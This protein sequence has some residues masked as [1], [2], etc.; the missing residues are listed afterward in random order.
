M[1]DLNPENYISENQ[2]DFEIQVLELRISDLK[3]QVNE[4]L[5]MIRNIE[6]NNDIPLHFAVQYQETIILLNDGIINLQNK[7][8]NLFHLKFYRPAVGH[9]RPAERSRSRARSNSRARSRSRSRS[10]SNSRARSN[11]RRRDQFESDFSD[12]DSEEESKKGVENSE[13]KD[14]YIKTSE[15]KEERNCSVCLT[16]FNA[17]EKYV[18]TPCKHSFHRT[19]ILEWFKKQTT[20]CNC[21]QN[22]KNMLTQAK[23]NLKIDVSLFTKKHLMYLCKK[24]KLRVRSSD[25]KDMQ[26][27]IIDYIHR[28]N[29]DVNKIF[30]KEDHM[31]YWMTLKQL[32]DI[33]KK[34]NIA[35]LNVCKEK[36]IEK[37][38]KAESILEQK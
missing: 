25:T 38:F 37:I 7:L 18:L 17:N 31:Y 9:L 10:R 32:K 8:S 4:N 30:T 22:L 13:I 20:C 23:L 26:F 33:A 24:F 19:C 14:E 6:K 36:L 34:Y 3:R 11:S 16:D 5:N 21:R 15:L 29:G 27:E 35:Q 12:S 28:N 1:A 2:L